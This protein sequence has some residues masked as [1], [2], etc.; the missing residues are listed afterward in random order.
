M[1][2]DDCNLFI[3]KILKEISNLGIDASQLQMDHV[4]YQTSS[5]HEYDG[6]K[7]EFKKFGE[8]VSEKIVGGR[9][10]GIYK[11]FKPLKFKQYVISAI[12]L[13]APKKGQVYPSGLEHAEFVLGE[14]FELFMKKYP[15]LPWDISAINQ[16]DFPMIKLRLAENMQVK[17]HLTPVL[18]IV[19]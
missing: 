19:E 2:L 3:E 17:F 13:I 14:S 12:E 15:N 6:L 10:V 4:G 18:E 16:P 8:M 1:T 9:R 11:F 5:D 7:E